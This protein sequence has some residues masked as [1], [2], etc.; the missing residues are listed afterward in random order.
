V[1]FAVRSRVGAGWTVGCRY[2]SDEIVEGGSELDDAVE[3]GVE[4][5]RAGM[6]FLSLSR[7]GKFED[8]QQPRVGHAAYPYTGPSGW[9]CMPTAIA[10]ARGPYG[11]NVE[12][13]AAIRAALRAAGLATP[14]VVTGGIHSFAQVEAILADG[15][16]DIVGAARQSLADPD[17]WEKVRLG[18]GAEVRRCDYTNYCEGLDQL[19]KPVTCRLWDKEA[20]DQPGVRLTP[21]GKRRLLAPG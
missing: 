18:R 2:L 8:A 7:G 21:D 11:R 16:A 12:P 17:W 1:L 10:D 13:A 4:L 14:V 15:G 3:F 19:H 5:A 20:L 9:E 6:D